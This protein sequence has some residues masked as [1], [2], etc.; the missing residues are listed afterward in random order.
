MLE[1]LLQKVGSPYNRMALLKLAFFADR[2]HV[3]NHA[4]P[5]SMD[6]YYA[7]K[8]GPA[9]SMLKDILSQYEDMFQGPAP[10]Q[11]VGKH[12]VELKV[13]RIDLDQFSKSDIKA[14][15]FSLENFSRMKDQFVLS[16]ITH[17]YPEWD[18]YA[19][20]FQAGKT[21]RE[22]ISYED[23]LKD[24]N[25]DHPI[26]KRWGFKDPFKKLSEGERNDLIQ[27]MREFSAMLV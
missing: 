27:E 6:D 4:R 26:L 14:M 7:F 15:E 3:R 10:I 8:F 23:F 18:Q 16:D 17:A 21:I 20:L 25:D 9:G 22:S 2:Y 11:A 1:Y 12:N 19:A 13:N 5:V 24:P